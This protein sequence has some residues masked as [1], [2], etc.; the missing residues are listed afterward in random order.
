MKLIIL[1]LTNA[2]S[3]TKTDF[4]HIGHWED[5]PEIVICEDA[6]VETTTIK[7]AMEFWK[8][9]GYEFNEQIKQKYCGREIHVPG[10]IRIVGQR[11]L[12][13][14]RY[15]AITDRN[16]Y[17]K[18]GMSYMLSANIKISNGDHQ[19][20]ELIIHELGHSL[21]IEHNHNDKSHIMHHL[22]IESETRYN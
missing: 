19:N 3:Y 4:N 21:G 9:I 20:L 5:N 6:K 12:D 17:V 8:N 7:S 1:L 15:Y 13:V 16:Y 22:V 18:N 10:E 14:V 11:N 2:L